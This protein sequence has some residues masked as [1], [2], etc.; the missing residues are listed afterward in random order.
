M[1]IRHTLAFAS[2][3]ALLAGCASAPI[4]KDGPLAWDGLGYKEEPTATSDVD[5]EMELS[6][7]RNPEA[8]RERVLATL[9]PRS[10]GW[11]ALHDEIEADQDKRLKAQM[12]ICSGCLPSK[13]QTANS[14]TSI[15]SASDGPS[16]VSR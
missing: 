7:R 4:Q 14:D 3:C 16:V 13:S 2:I 9:D 15:K 6:S 1:L 12:R 10:A 11:Q 8:K 5:P